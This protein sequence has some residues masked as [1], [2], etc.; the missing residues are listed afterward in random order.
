V[1]DRA[2]HEA[3]SGS[4]SNGAASARE[5]SATSAGK[6]QS[7]EDGERPPLESAGEARGTAGA[8]SGR[9]ERTTAGRRPGAAA[10]AD[11][12]AG[13]RDVDVAENEPEQAAPRAQKKVVDISRGARPAAEPA[14]PETP[15]A[16]A[17]P[18]VRRMARELGV[19]IDD[20]PGTDANG[21]IS[22]DD[23]KAY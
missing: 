7:D 11:R 12:G 13:A 8:S 15:P 5:V 23:V 18:S 14:A 1:E 4:S 20:V 16:P 3:A 9:S 6:E 19:D 21:R 17:A 2:A 22:V 10:T